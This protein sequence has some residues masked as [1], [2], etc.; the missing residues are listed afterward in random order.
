EHIA[1]RVRAPERKVEKLRQ[2]PAPGKPDR[3]HAEAVLRV[4][5]DLLE[6]GVEGEMSER[7]FVVD[8]E[9]VKAADVEH[10]RGRGKH[11]QRLTH[12]RREAG[13]GR[14]TMYGRFR[15]PLSYSHDVLSVSSPSAARVAV[16]GASGY[17]GGRLL[18]PLLDAG[19]QVR[20]I[21]RRP[22]Y[23]VARVPAA[24]EVVRGDAFD[25]ASLVAALSGCD[26]AY[27]L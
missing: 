2:V 19:Y 12:P 13:V 20:A 27:Y 23:L 24:I 11:A 10:G 15:A 6:I 8:A 25:R 1:A 4:A 3:Q 7:R 22:E 14:V 16:L 26:Y 17:V 9:V 18:R 5:Q 21:A